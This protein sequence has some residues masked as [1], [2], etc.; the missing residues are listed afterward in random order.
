VAIAACVTL[1]PSLFLAMKT[2]VE[3]EAIHLV[4]TQH[5]SIGIIE[6]KTSTI[7]KILVTFCIVDS[8]RSIGS[9]LGH[10]AQDG[11]VPILSPALIP[12]AVLV[13]ADWWLLLWLL[14]QAM[15]VVEPQST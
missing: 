9:V 4:L 13:S 12:L 11:S 2:L 15:I 7:S 3:E 1:S 6:I 8:A 14:Q 5:F 10:D